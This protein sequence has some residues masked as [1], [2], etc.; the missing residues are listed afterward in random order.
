M[1]FESENANEWEEVKS[2]HPAAKATESTRLKTMTLIVD[3][4]P[5]PQKAL[6]KTNK[7]AS[8]K[9]EG[10][11]NKSPDRQTRTTAK[12]RARAN[13]D[14]FPFH[15]DNQGRSAWRAGK[16]HA[17]TYTMPDD[18]DEIYENLFHPTRAD[19]HSANPLQHI[20]DTIG[21]QTLT[22]IAPPENSS[23]KVLRIWGPTLK[24]KLACQQLHA[25]LLHFRNKAAT[26]WEKTRSGPSEQR[27]RELNATLEQ[28]VLSEAFRRDPGSKIDALQ[29]G[30]FLWPVNEIQ[31]G[32]VLGERFEAL[33]PIRTELGCYLLW[34]PKTSIITVAATKS[35]TIY[36]AIQRLRVTFLELLAR[37]A[38]P[39]R[40]TLLAPLAVGVGRSHVGFFAWTETVQTPGRTGPPRPRRRVLPILCG[41]F[42]HPGELS[43][44]NNFQPGHAMA[45]E[46]RLANSIV[47]QMKSLCYYR[48]HI[49]LRVL[50][51]FYYLTGVAGTLTK[52]LSLAEF[53]R[54]L[55]ASEVSGDLDRDLRQFGDGAGLLACCRG[56]TSLIGPVH[57]TSLEYEEPKYSAS[58]EV[59][60][61]N[62][63]AN[64]QLHLEFEPNLQGGFDV[65]RRLWE[66]VEDAAIA[67]ESVTGQWRGGRQPLT[68][69]M[70]DLESTTS[71]QFAVTTSNRVDEVHI[72][73]AM[74]EFDSKV[75]LR[76][77][78][79]SDTPAGRHREPFVTF[80][81]PGLRV[82]TR[83]EMKH[84]RYSIHGSP[85]LLEI[86][87]RRY[88]T[89]GDPRPGEPL[90]AESPPQTTWEA[91][92]YHREWDN[93]FLDQSTLRI[94]EKGPRSVS[95]PL[96]FPATTQPNGPPTADGF[97]DFLQTIGL[98]AR[99][100]GSRNA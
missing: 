29:K 43:S 10:K 37:G 35:S 42:D 21:V 58:F 6:K 39:V 7:A 95:L 88:I 63:A 55:N 2:Q 53:L 77:H 99:L 75:V 64:S 76:T 46:K 34:D 71:W 22:F 16:P 65:T 86:T 31:P 59:N 94:G 13:P 51:G 52:D 4:E 12:S 91:T 23:E 72:T 9:S 68:A 96:L 47:A 8:K 61:G 90:P 40:L 66:V 36:A 57:G 82:S 1:D 89:R 100:L 93:I 84:Y 78:L 73:T 83:T 98:V 60:P 24:I 19:G 5:V 87:R 97:H 44:W 92:M 3:R 74:K 48:G 38:P 27:I 14:K 85:F 17:G 49:R 20:L 32:P 28:T 33:D 69:T 11:S 70:L 26:K 81:N 50:F 18:S 45:N 30:F 56:A 54:Q 80:I 15:V 41:G 62:G 25:T 79:G 67:R